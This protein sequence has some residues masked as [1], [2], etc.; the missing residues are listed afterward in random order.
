MLNVLGFR[1]PLDSG[2][3]R[4][5]DFIDINIL[6]L[7]G[8]NGLV[9]DEPWEY[10]QLPGRAN[11]CSLR[12]DLSNSVASFTGLVVHEVFHLYQAGY[13][14]IQRV[15]VDEG[16]ADW[17]GSPFRPST[18]TQVVAKSLP[19]T[20]AEMTRVFSESPSSPFW[21]RLALLMDGS[22]GF[23]DLPDH[24]LDA[25]NA[26][27]TPIIKSSYLRGARFVA[28]LY[29]ALDAED[30]VV[31]AQQGWAQYNWTDANQKSAAHDL[32]LLR[33]IQRVVRRTGITS[34][35]IEAFLAIQ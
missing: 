26:N 32:R 11:V 7:G 31:S 12:F 5:V 25:T 29:Q 13:S 22:D 14:M 8:P 3:Y 16:I 21:R 1:D 18:A 19:S 33:V 4:A 28:A 35:E 23:I 27:G 34:P 20:M 24:L 15:W 30:D 9:Y 6:A 17:V 2:R 10:S